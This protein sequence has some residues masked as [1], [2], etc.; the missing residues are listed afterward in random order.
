V[1]VG[2]V[3]DSVGNRKLWGVP[4]TTAKYM[5]IL[6]ATAGW[7]ALIPVFH[8]RGNDNEPVSNRPRTNNDTQVYHSPQRPGWDTEKRV[9]RVSAYCANCEICCGE[10]ARIP[11]SGG[12]RRTASGHIIKSDDYGRIVAAPKSIP[13]NTTIEIPGTGR[14]IALDRG[15]AIKAAGETYRGQTLKYDRLDI[16]MKDHQTALAYGVKFLECK[17]IE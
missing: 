17:I 7:I 4:M 14:V 9:F 5:A 3:R 10:W 11:V 2:G 6:L 15:G 8:I 12:N 1:G 13:F 16:L